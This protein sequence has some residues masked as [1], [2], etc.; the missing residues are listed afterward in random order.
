[1]PAVGCVAGSN[2]RSY[3]QLSLLPLSGLSLEHLQAGRG[4]GVLPAGLARPVRLNQDFSSLIENIS[5]SVPPV[6]Q[7]F[8]RTVWSGVSCISHIFSTRTVPGFSPE[9]AVGAV[10]GHRGIQAFI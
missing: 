4:R 3:T 5:V 10:L 1:M 2:V 6:W 8:P 9:E 7:R